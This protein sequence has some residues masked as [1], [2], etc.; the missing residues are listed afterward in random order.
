M[1]NILDSI[2]NCNISIST[3]AE[4]AESF[5]TLLIIGSAP[6]IPTGNTRSVSSYSSMDEVSAIGWEEDCKVYRAAKTAFMQNPQPQKIYIAVR[7]KSGDTTE[8]ITKTVERAL[9]AKGWYGLAVADIAESEY[10]AVASAI[11]ASEKMFFFSVNEKKNPLKTI[12]YMRTAGIYTGE[13]AD[14]DEFLHIAWM[15]R[16]FG[17]SPGSETWA[18]KQLAGIN[19]DG[20]SSGD[21]QVLEDGGLNYYIEC[22][23]KDIVMNGK[24]VGGEWIDT[25]RFRDWLKNEMQLRIFNLFMANP[26]IPYTDSG[27]S[28]VEN[29]MTAVLKA[30][31]Q[32][33][34]I[35]ETSYDENDNS[36]KGF[37][38][39]VPTAGSLTEA[40]RAYRKLSGCAF[41][42]RLSG[43][44]HAAELN[45][46]LIF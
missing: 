1:S 22:A 42:A 10:D 25:I 20:L 26:K 32:A 21:R 17:Y 19:S 11:E 18:F 33:G 27:I 37:T 45:G 43:A 15:V 36:I 44:I 38:V 9:E 34:G 8:V 5:G 16:G 35:A 41:T 13:A 6:E 14:N 39:K 46:S 24:A 23:G 2:V 40:Q 29:Q 3:Q 31:Q 28:L 12:K 4:N 7:E 30:G